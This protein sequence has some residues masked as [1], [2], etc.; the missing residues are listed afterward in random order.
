MRVPGRT[1]LEGGVGWG[2]EGGEEWG[3]EKEEM[4]GGGMEEMGMTQAAGGEGAAH[5]EM[6]V[7]GEP[8]GESDDE[9]EEVTER[10]CDEGAATAGL[11]CRLL[12]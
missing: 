8:G 6:V 4:S 12:R 10:K 11:P 5:L 2:E 9:M 7:G 3:C 1:E